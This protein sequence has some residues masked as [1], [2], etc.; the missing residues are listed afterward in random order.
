[1]IVAVYLPSVYQNCVCSRDINIMFVTAVDF[2]LLFRPLSFASLGVLQLLIILRI[3]RFATAKT[4]FGMIALCIGVS[5]IF[6]ASTFRLVHNRGELLICYNS[7][8]PN[9]Y[10]V[11]CHF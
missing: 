2:G 4:A 5:L 3:K 6:V 10:M 9:I 1:M 7:Y 11:M 8:C